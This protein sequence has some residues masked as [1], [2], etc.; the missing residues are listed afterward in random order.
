MTFSGD[1]LLGGPQAGVLV[2]THEAVE[3]VR[4]H[5]LM[6][7]VRPDKMTLAALEATLELYRAQRARTDVPVLRML[8]LTRVELAERAQRLFRALGPSNGPLA[9]EVVETT[10]AVGGGA[11]PLCEPASFALRVSARDGRSA[12]DLDEALRHHDPAIVGR[13]VDDSVLLDVRTVDE[14][15]FQVLAQA[16]TTLA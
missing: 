13:I 6:R 16:L 10:S 1:K 2:G 15:D 8:A 4:S 9:L 11:L 14:A 5:P 7:V 3:S 12:R